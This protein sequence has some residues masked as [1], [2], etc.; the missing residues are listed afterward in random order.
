LLCR[1]TVDG[2]EEDVSLFEGV[3]LEEPSAPTL[4]T[5]LQPTTPAPI[6]SPAP[7]PAY[8]E[9]MGT[10][11]AMAPPPGQYV[12]L[13]PACLL[14]P[15]P[16]APLADTDEPRLTLRSLLVA[17]HV[18][19]CG[20]MQNPYAY[21][22]GKPPESP[23]LSG[24][25]AQAIMHMP[26]LPDALSEWTNFLYAH[27]TTSLLVATPPALKCDASVWSSDQPGEQPGDWSVCG[28]LH[29]PMLKAWLYLS[30]ATLIFS[31]F[32][33]FPGKHCAH[34]PWTSLSSAGASWHVA[35]NSVLHSSQHAR[36][37]MDAA[38]VFV[39]L[40][41]IIAASMHVCKCCKGDPSLA[42]PVAVT[43]VLAM[44]TAFI[45]G[46]IVFLIALQWLFLVGA[47]SHPYRAGGWTCLA[48]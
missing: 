10:P 6:P 38:G 14:L 9:A 28:V 36:H 34:R 47:F 16:P 37:G 2:N 35:H 44:V 7:P 24:T 22:V 13:P 20:G 30:I 43:Y 12:R 29:R 11:A 48:Q 1:T 19:V 15:L 3:Q 8:S 31:I 4:V 18:L 23:A 17:Y 40:L 39:G 41:G 27:P 32:T 45:D 33:F 21:S 42:G 5:P 25:Q 46:F 26:D